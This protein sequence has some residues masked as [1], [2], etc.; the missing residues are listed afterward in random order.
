[1]MY[2]LRAAG[3][4]M[5]CLACGVA[6]GR[7]AAADARAA[8]ADAITCKGGLDAMAAVNRAVDADQ[9][10]LP[11]F[12]NVA[13]ARA[14]GLDSTFIRSS[15]QPVAALGLSSNY[16]YFYSRAE[17]YLVVKSD[18]PYDALKVTAAKLGLQKEAGGDERWPIYSKAAGDGTLTVMPGESGTGSRY[19]LVGCKYELD[20]VQQ[21]LANA[22]R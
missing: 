8:I 5:I 2:F 15:A 1:M 20:A 10:L 12:R 21:R 22:A 4:G 11:Q 19:Y 13:E 16:V 18:Q 17:I 3:L 6:T 14:A 7:A 9:S